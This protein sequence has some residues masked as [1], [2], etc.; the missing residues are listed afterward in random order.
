MKD[1]IKYRRLPKYI[2]GDELSLKISSYP[3]FLKY[4]S[5]RLGNKHS[6]LLELCTGIAVG[7][8]FLESNFKKL[9]GIELDSKIVK[10]ASSNIEKAGLKDKVSIIQSDVNDIDGFKYLKPDVVIYDIPYW[11]N[12]DADLLK[13]NPDL[14]L[15]FKKINEHLIKNIIIYS[16]PHLDYDYYKKLLNIEFEL[17]EIYINMKHDRNVLFFGNLVNKIG[18]YKELLV[19]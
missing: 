14:K 3:I 9:Y 5:K 16:P 15:L 10:I 7:L 13:R 18:T 11:S 1:I 8:I 2:E 6:F 17:V 12:H 19:N 4:L